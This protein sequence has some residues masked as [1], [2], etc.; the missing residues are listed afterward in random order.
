MNLDEY[1]RRITFN[2][3]I[4]D[5][6]KL[7]LDLS[8]ELDLQREVDYYRKIEKYKGFGGVEQDIKKE[9]FYSGLFHFSLSVKVFKNSLF[10]PFKF[11]QFI[12]PSEIQ[13][14]NRDKVF[15]DKAIE[16]INEIVKDKLVKYNYADF[17]TDIAALIPKVSEIGFSIVEDDEKG[18]TIDNVEL[19]GE[20]KQSMNKELKEHP[21]ELK[22][23]FDKL[24]GKD[25]FVSQFA[26][27]YF[28]G[29][30]LIGPIYFSLYAF[31]SDSD[32]S[33]VKLTH[34]MLIYTEKEEDGQFFYT[35]VRRVRDIASRIRT[36]HIENLI[37]KNQHEAIKSAKAAIMSR[38]LS[39]NLGSHVMSYLKQSLK[40][41]TDMEK[42]GA[43]E[44]IS[45]KGQQLPAIEVK[46]G[47]DITTKTP[48]LPFLV[49]TGRFISYL[50]ERQD[51]IATVSTDYIPFPS[52]VNFKDGIYDELNPDY[53]YLRHSEWAGHKP[54]NILL[55]N[56]ARSEGLSR[57]SNGT[58]KGSN[59]VIKYRS[60]D[61]L[62]VSAFEGLKKN[63]KGND[64]ASLRNWDFSLPGGIMGRQAVFS[65]VENIIR[66]AAKHGVRNAGDDLVVTF[67]IIDPMGEDGLHSFDEE[68][69][70]RYAKTKS[71]NYNRYSK[72]I[73]DL[74]IATLTTNTKVDNDALKKIQDAIHETL[75]DDSGNLKQSNKGIK[76]M[77]IS[78]AWLRHI[79]VEELDECD[80]FEIAPILRVYKQEGTD[81]LQYVFCLPRVKEVALI[82]KDSDAN[83][84]PENTEKTSLLQKKDNREWINNGW[85][86]YTLEE[87]KVLKNK[88]FS[89]II[90]DKELAN[91]KEEVRKCSTHRFFI[92]ADKTDLQKQEIQFSMRDCLG[93]SE[94]VDF[95]GAVLKLFK[96]L[97]NEDDKFVIAISDKSLEHVEE[98]THVVDIQKLSSTEDNL[99]DYQYIYRTHN[100][101]KTEFEKFV[102]DYGDMSKLCFIEGITGG[103]STD[104]L[105]R[106]TVIND[107]W[108]F[109]HVH[110]MKTRVAIFDE[111][112]FSNVTGIELSRI[113]S[114]V[115]SWEE[116]LKDMTD[117]E[118][119]N[120]VN[121]Y[122]YNRRN[123]ISGDSEFRIIYRKYTRQE[124]IQ[125]AKKNYSTVEFPIE[126]HT[127]LVFQKKGIDLFT[128]TR[129][130]D[131]VLI[132]GVCASEKIGDDMDNSKDY[133]KVK[134][135]GRMDFQR[136]VNG[137][138]PHLE[139]FKQTSL[140]PVQEYDYL[141][142]HQGLLDKV[143]ESYEK[144]SDSR[145][146][147]KEVTKALCDEFLKIKSADNDFLQGLIIHSGRSKPNP[148]DMPQ[149][150]P[151]L[152]YSAIENALFD[153][154]Y[155]LVEAL[156]HACFENHHKDME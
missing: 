100:D 12:Q 61:G 77:V 133:G 141:C 128:M 76:E 25:S 143:Y 97:A 27:V 93:F 99:R 79:R 114:E 36:K 156:D 58:Q 42:T 51:Y 104:R 130:S 113:Q 150:Q 49:G 17:F 74:Y 30:A 29:L 46:E 122:D 120:F 40:S 112:M 59:I 33:R 83:K 124:V 28:T 75:V 103:N 45:P 101:T 24:M 82:V 32:D 73:D 84:I 44:E 119:R 81:Y 3:S 26:N 109:K 152:Q 21:E 67:D 6:D 56:I 22:I 123:I 5:L 144:N 154:K 153:C 80:R 116:L 110:A 147:R 1:L 106:H 87:Y 149:N 71:A 8:H 60:F 19:N 85:Y 9:G 129:D 135:I 34:F 126:T 132:W 41:V 15:E 13:S 11:L 142:L 50:Q 105:I 91:Q 137:I 96:Q 145:E 148:D 138:T 37:K 146:N 70:K 65:I 155:T 139:L 89:F 108:S 53:R 55:E 118:A 127:P 69:Q 121:K 72:D 115:Q 107:M 140:L 14:G 92:E 35:R 39:H 52:V 111:R 151:F 63:D 57:Q 31:D 64:Y 23:I 134:P 90:L 4:S 38:N 16:K 62:N 47:Q 7:Y 98:N 78:A 43:L 102:R 68:F 66:N 86:V 48:E 54:A 94:K 2:S 136:D 18:L 20:D 131:G 10:I 88:S 95:E 117:E 125:F